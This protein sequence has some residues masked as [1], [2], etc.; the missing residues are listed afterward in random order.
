MMLRTMTLKIRMPIAMVALTAAI[1]SL[2]LSQSFAVTPT[3][4]WV[5]T[6]P[7]DKGFVHT[8][9]A[10]DNTQIAIFNDNDDIDPND[11]TWYV[12]R[13]GSD[14]QPLYKGA[15]AGPGYIHDTAIGADSSVYL[16][17]I[18][19]GTPGGR[20]LKLKPGAQSAEI[21]KTWD[22][23]LL[24]SVEFI[25]DK[26]YTVE[27]D[28]S[29]GTCLSTMNIF[30]SDGTELKTLDNP[31][32]CAG[33]WQAAANVLTAYDYTNQRIAYLNPDTLNVTYQPIPAGVGF[34]QRSMSANGSY[35]F[36]GGGSQCS[37]A[38]IIRISPSGLVYDVPVSQIFQNIGSGCYVTGIAMLS[39][40]TTAIATKD[41][42]P[43]TAD[44]RTPG[45][46]RK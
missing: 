41:N 39:D 45:C 5:A 8:L 26:V 44:C 22:T 33:G 10:P 16:L 23:G 14:A 12:A 29:S 17:V 20:L 21:L 3:I 37:N 4:G 32:G 25:K 27:F 13:L 7:A 2:F 11:Q 36:F 1:G 35:V 24:D 15:I 9:P 19:L 46:K 43:D 40:D 18:T 31:A 42:G 38:R 28:A 6:V 30:G 34:G